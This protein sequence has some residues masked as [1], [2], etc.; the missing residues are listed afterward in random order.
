MILK[1]ALNDEFVTPCTAGNLSYVGME[2]GS[3]KA[4]EILPDTIGNIYKENEKYI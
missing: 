1:V 2:D 4:C 3:I